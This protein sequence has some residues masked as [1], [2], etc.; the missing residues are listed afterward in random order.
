[1]QVVLKI[2]QWLV[3]YIILYNSELGSIQECQGNNLKRG[4][5]SLC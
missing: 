1:M 4:G 2:L 5:G 3:W